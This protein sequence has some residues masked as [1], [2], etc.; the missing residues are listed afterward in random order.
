M[1]GSKLLI[2][3]SGVGSRLGELTRHTSKALV[4][5]GDVP[6]ITHILRKY[7]F[8]MPVVVTLG[9]YGSHV[10]QY[11]SLAHPQRTFEFV[12]VEDY[13]VGLLNSIMAAEKNLQCPFIYNACDNFCSWFEDNKLAG[14]VLVGF[15]SR[16]S[17]NY[18]TIANGRIMEKGEFSYDYAYGGICMIHDY[19]AF[20]SIANGMTDKTGG[21]T[22]VINK[23]IDSGTRFSVAVSEDW[24][25]IGSPKQLES[26][27]KRIGA[28]HTVL[29]KAAENI[30]FLGD[31]VVK[32]FADK[33]IVANRVE[34]MKMLGDAC[35]EVL[36]HTENFFLYRYF[37]GSS[38]SKQINPV[39]L[40]KFLEWADGHPRL[41]T[42]VNTT[43]D[44]FQD[45]LIT[46][47][48]KKTVARS[49]KAEQRFG[50]TSDHVVINSVLVPGVNDMLKKIP[51]KLF[52]PSRGAKVIHGD[53]VLENIV[54][55]YAGTFKLIDIRQDFAGETTCG[56]IYY[57]F[58]KLLHNIMLEHGAINKG[59]FTFKKNGDMIEVDLMS[60]L[61]RSQCLYELKKFVLRKRYDY[62][63]VEMLAA[64]IWINM[65]ALHEYPFGPFLYYFG[66]YALWTTMSRQGSL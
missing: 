61:T 15:E 63:L 32:F 25:D 59:L 18:R 40:K 8:S 47:Y 37:G 60:S 1:A 44:R 21:E 64:I 45:M 22:D 52:N 36:G 46:F 48:Y 42:D 28:T 27:R 20:W 33:S 13:G 55:D 29:E 17:E 58:A 38:L 10:K 31:K 7:P 4:R 50:L 6:A 24:I 30:F 35:P 57:D 9:H 49:D 51:K 11:L 56:D 14:N 23:M 19:E 54:H 66:R 12:D 65:S 5:V 39:R 2:T 53:M 3:T 43:V 62:G 16:D 34:R 41:W 26:A